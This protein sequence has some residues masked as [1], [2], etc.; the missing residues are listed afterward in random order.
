[1]RYTMQFY[2]WTTMRVTNAGPVCASEQSDQR[3][4]YS[5]KFLHEWAVVSRKPK[6]VNDY[7]Q[8]R[9]QSQTADKPMAP[10]CTP[11]WRKNLRVKYSN[12]SH[13]SH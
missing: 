5:L 11:S 2:N 4:C 6:V 1:M 12:L 8:E 7:D 10:P 13:S 9:P 3:F